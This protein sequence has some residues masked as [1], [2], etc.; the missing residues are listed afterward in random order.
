MSNPTKKS[1]CWQYFHQQHSQGFTLIELLVV[2]VI[3]GVISA[4][5]LPSYLNQAAKARGS[6][7][8]S[9]LGSINRAQQAY[10]YEQGTF[11][12]TLNDLKKFAVVDGN[13]YSYSI[14]GNANAALASATPIEDNYKVYSAGVGTSSNDTFV[15]VIC[16]S[17]NLNSSLTNNTA[18]AS[19][20]GGALATAS[21]TLGREV[22]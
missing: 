3:V 20:V 7:A 14:V 9:M 13:G 8:K 22:R 1:F 18:Q 5:A 10:R 12:A 11:A 16:E 2:I 21:C 4:I 17:E 6:G 19:V 15:Q